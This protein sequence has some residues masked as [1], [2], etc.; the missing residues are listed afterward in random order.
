MQKDG[1]SM[2][3]AATGAAVGTNDEAKCSKEGQLHSELVKYED[4][5]GDYEHRKRL[6]TS[7]KAQKGNTKTGKGKIFTVAQAHRVVACHTPRYV[8]PVIF[9]RSSDINLWVLN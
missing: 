4:E 1:L 7:I 2:K 9:R 6:F 3:L 8:G 5:I